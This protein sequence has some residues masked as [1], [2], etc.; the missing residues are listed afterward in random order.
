MCVC[1]HVKILKFLLVYKPSSFDNFIF[2]TFFTA[3][4]FD[5]LQFHITKQCFLVFGNIQNIYT[6]II[7]NTMNAN[8][9]YNP[10][11][12]HFVKYFKCIKSWQMI[13]TKRNLNHICLSTLSEI[14]SGLL[15]LTA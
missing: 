14:V 3:I 2:L 5:I 8:L 12:L 15:S 6:S 7:F 10:E 9:N 13:N 11:E 1:A 4:L